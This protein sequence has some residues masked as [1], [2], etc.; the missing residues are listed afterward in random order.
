MKPPDDV[1]PGVALAPVARVTPAAAPS[2]VSGVRAASRPTLHTFGDHTADAPRRPVWSVPSSDGAMPE[3][4]LGPEPAVVEHGVSS[5]DGREGSTEDLDARA[6]ASAMVS[7]TRL[8]AR[9]NEAL[10]ASTAA[11]KA[12]A[13]GLAATRSTVANLSVQ[14]EGVTE[15]V[16]GLSARVAENT[17]SIERLRA[18]NVRQDSQIGRLRRIL[19]TM[20]DLTRPRATV[21]VLLALTL[22]NVFGP[23]VASAWHKVKGAVVGAPAASASAPVLVPLAPPVGTGETP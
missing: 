3:V 13:E 11:L 23:Y 22:A 16:R 18:D 4:G 21:P 19:A 10:V 15:A 6:I 8:A 1:P 17:G 12:S 9:T 20:A 14:V 7:A 2:A 5:E